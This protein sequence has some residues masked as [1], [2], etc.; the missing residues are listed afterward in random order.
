MI[1]HIIHTIF[2]LF[3]AFG[4]ILIL[5]TAGASDFGTLDFMGLVVRGSVGIM[6]IV[7]GFVGLKLS[8]CKYIA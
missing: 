3:I 7:I 1:R 8:G 5:G 4:F 2:G 6:S